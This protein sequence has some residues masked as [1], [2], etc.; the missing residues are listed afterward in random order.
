MD[1]KRRSDTQLILLDDQL[2]PISV[3]DHRTTEHQEIG[4]CLRFC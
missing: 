3:P 4:L 1:Y 2:D